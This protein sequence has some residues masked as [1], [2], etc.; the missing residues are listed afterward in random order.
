ML[1]PET[2]IASAALFETLFN[3]RTIGQRDENS[4]SILID[5]LANDYLFDELNFEANPYVAKKFQNV[6]E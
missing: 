2:L 6:P 1:S 5:S 4:T 3:K